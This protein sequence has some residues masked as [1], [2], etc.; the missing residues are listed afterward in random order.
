MGDAGSYDVGN[1]E[2]GTG[3][4]ICMR[5]PSPCPRQHAASAKGRK[6]YVRSL[7][8]ESLTLGDILESLVGSHDCG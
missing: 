8:Q 3:A 7:E 5:S 1:I 2:G 6:M 4:T